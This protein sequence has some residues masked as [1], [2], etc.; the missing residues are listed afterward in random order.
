MITPGGNDYNLHYLIFPPTIL[1]SV[2]LL[3]DGTYDVFL[4][5]MMNVE[6]QRKALKHEI[7][8]IDKGHLYN[9]I[10]TVRE[11]EMEAG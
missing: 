5:A 11:M 4:N 6:M 8:H 2:V 9:D 1:G 3:E 10:C 7:N